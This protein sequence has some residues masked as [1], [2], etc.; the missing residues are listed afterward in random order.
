MKYENGQKVYDKEH[1]EEFI[2]DDKTDKY[3]T[4]TFPERFELVKTNLQK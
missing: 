1:K 4:D 3:V 2:Y